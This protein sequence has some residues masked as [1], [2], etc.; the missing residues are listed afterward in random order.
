MRAFF[1]FSFEATAYHGQR[2]HVDADVP[3]QDHGERSS[4][5]QA[6]GFP[7]S[8]S[9]RVKSGIRNS[10]TTGGCDTD[11]RPGDGMKDR[12]G[13]FTAVRERA[14]SVHRPLAACTD[15]AVR[16]KT[17]RARKDSRISLFVCLFMKKQ[18]KKTEADRMT[19]DLRVN[20][21][22]RPSRAVKVFTFLTSILEK[23]KG[24]AWFSPVGHCPLNMD[25]S[26]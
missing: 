22:G 13:F 4:S 25:P 2:L 1:S 21:E 17:C 10:S 5:T 24:G 26:F 16:M 20:I 19:L 23:K 9:G 12:G 6:G 15:T 3:F 14:R 11:S 18:N 8:T 7:Q